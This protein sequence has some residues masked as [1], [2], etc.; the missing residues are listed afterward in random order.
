MEIG[1]LPGLPD[2]VLDILNKEGGDLDEIMERVRFKTMQI[3]EMVRDQ[4]AKSQLENQ[5]P[6][7]KGNV[8]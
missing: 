1:N 7:D 8:A 5:A 4:Y 2:G 3:R 6:S